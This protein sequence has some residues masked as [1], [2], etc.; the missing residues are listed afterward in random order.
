MPRCDR[1]QECGAERR[2][3]GERQEAREQDRHHHR[4]TELLVDDA[5]CAREEGHGNKHG[6]QHERDAD[7]RAGNLAHRLA[8]RLLRRQSLLGHDA[9]D[10]L[11]HDDGVVHEDADRQHH[12]EHCQDVDREAGDKHDRTGAEQRH[13]HDERRNHRVTDVLQEQEHYDEH[14]ADRFD[15]RVDH[16]LD[17]RLDEGRRVVGDLVAYARREELCQ[18]VHLRPDALRRGHGIGGRR[19][20]DADGRGRFAVQSGGEVVCFAA[21]FNARDVAQPDRGAVRVGAQD[22]RTELLGRGE[23]AA[24]EDGRGDLLVDGVRLRA[25]AAGRDLR[26]LRADGSGDIVDRQTQA[27]HLVRIHPDAHRALGGEERGAADARYAP[28]FADDVAAHIVAKAD[29]IGIAVVGF[30]PDHHQEAGAGLLDAHA[31]LGHRTRKARLDACDAVLHLHLRLVDIR[32][33]RE[34]HVDG[35]ATGG[36]RGR[37]RNRSAPGTPFSSSSIG[38]VTL[39]YMSS[40]EA[41]G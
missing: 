13:R 4:Q 41:P 16:L 28:D 5:H 23:L 17:G 15:E 33:G 11:H 25:D 26:I 10:V 18:F 14:E 19:Q 30:Q 6:R 8:G 21:D 34:G 40:G 12:G 20:L 22:D 35:D 36:F 31:L 7:E 37:L 27:D 3:Q 1:L 9:L 24:N 2:R 32:A 38:R 39:R 29:R